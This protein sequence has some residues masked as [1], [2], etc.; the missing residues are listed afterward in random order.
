MRFFRTAEGGSRTLTPL[1]ARDFESPASANSPPRN[2]PIA[3][4]PCGPPLA[5]GNLLSFDQILSLAPASSQANLQGQTSS[6][7]S[8]VST[9][10]H[11]IALKL[12]MLCLF[13]GLD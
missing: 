6:N 11:R 12:P 8:I 10:S 7:E 2:P 4:P 9:S 13:F 5:D 3:S 1:R